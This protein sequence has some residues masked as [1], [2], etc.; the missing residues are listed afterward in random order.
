MAGEGRPLT[1]MEAL[2]ELINGNRL[3]LN[4][5]NTS[6]KASIVE[7]V[8]EIV[9]GMGAVIS[10]GITS[11]WTTWSSSKIFTELGLKAP[12]VNPSFTGTVTVPDNAL[13]I[14]KVSGLQTALNDKITLDPSNVVTGTAA[15]VAG[16]VNN[17][18]SGLN[19]VVTG[20][21]NNM[22]SGGRSS[23]NGGIANL[24]S[25]LYSVAE[26]DGS[27]ADQGGM[28]AFGSRF[29][30]SGDAQSFEMLL[31]RIGISEAPTTLLNAS[32]LFPTMPLNTTW[33][34]SGIV[35]A[36][37]TNLNGMNA[38]WQFNMLAIRNGGSG[39][40]VEPSLTIAEIGKTAGC[41]WTIAITSDAASRVIITCTGEAATTI[42]WVAALTV[43]QISN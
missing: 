19:A 32:N 42:R 23:V 26:G 31:K 3:D 28:R 24:A 43:V 14:P 25:G 18:A 5:L 4:N 36:K 30:N 41:P 40:L 7:A 13:S 27:V 33:A 15:V 34:I 29:V 38:A 12:K 2:R 37:R 6:N 20:G 21:A 39:S 10:D 9:S 22:A 11:T 17:T 8:N 16:G 1:K 35:S